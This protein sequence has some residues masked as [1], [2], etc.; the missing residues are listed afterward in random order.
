MKVFKSIKWRL[1][2]GYGLVLAGVL[3]ALVG[4]SYQMDQDRQFSNINVEMNSH[5]ATIMDL[6]RFP[7]PPP[8][9]GPDQPPP[10]RPFSPGHPPGGLH[11][12]RR[13]DFNLNTFFDATGTNGFY[14][15]IWTWDGSRE[16]MHSTNAPPDLPT[17]VGH[18]WVRLRGAYRESF[19]RVP[20]EMPP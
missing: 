16:L 20:A 3:L 7:P 4:T 11:L 10:Q 12:P 19:V 13:D 8:R 15:V 14:Y 1:Q 6:M 5:I 9:H 18:E 2:T 17:P